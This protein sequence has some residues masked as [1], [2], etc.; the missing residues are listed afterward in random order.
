MA[1]KLPPLYPEFM[2]VASR[3]I[4]KG[5][6]RGKEYGPIARTRVPAPLWLLYE[7]EDI[8]QV[9]AKKNKS[10]RKGIVEQNSLAF[11][12]QGLLTSDGEFWKKQRRLEQ[13]AF[14]R[15]K[16]EGYAETMAWCS[17]QLLQRWEPG[18]VV[19]L[20]EEMAAITLRIINLTAFGAD[21]AESA[22]AVSRALVT[23][24]DRVEG[25]GRNMYQLP[26]RIPTKTNRRYR[27]E[28]RNLDDIIYG[29]I[30]QRREQERRGE[31][32]NEDDLLGM[33]YAVKDAD[34]GERMT[35]EQLRNEVVTIFAAGH[36]TT[37]NAL[38]W[39]FHLLA[40]NPEIDELLAQEVEEVLGGKLPSFEDVPR[41]RWADAIF[42]EAMRLYPP[43]YAFTREATED[44]E[45]GGYTMP[46]GTEVVF[47]QWVTQRDPRFFHEPATFRPE[48][49]LDGSADEAPRYAYFP[50]GG[51]QRQ[52]IG[53]GFAEM[54]GPIILAA[55]AQ[56]YRLTYLE[57][58]REVRLR[59]TVTLRPSYGPKNEYGLPPMVIEEREPARSG[60][61]TA[62]AEV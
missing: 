15:K 16:I 55:I 58:G 24:G 37:A 6:E 19:D 42:K 1:G 44:V 11:M 13:P 43:I 17:E 56:R 59:P 35:D 53:K 33:L 9:L 27:R 49:W 3:D 62:S 48:R 57:P 12:G 29:I 25:V 40:E 23:I 54:E 30:E 39:V 26:E 7:P 51:G 31:D 36:E 14:H 8:E 46:A 22:D 21:V 60:A 5:L 4:L 45:I 61:A 38:T 20:H 2:F 52:C 18:Q 32:V 50:F 28:M 41:L 47:S 34:T 10:F